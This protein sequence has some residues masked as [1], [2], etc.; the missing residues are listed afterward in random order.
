M[1]SFKEFEEQKRKEIE[2]GRLLLMELIDKK[3]KSGQKLKS[4]EEEYF[5]SLLNLIRDMNGKKVHDDTLDLEECKNYNFIEAYGLLWHDLNGIKKHK[6][7]RGEYYSKQQ[8]ERFV[9]YLNSEFINWEKI[10]Q[11]ENHKDSR[12]NN[13][14]IETRRHLKS[15]KRQ[16]DFFIDGIFY[17]NRYYKSVRKKIILFSKYV[18]LKAVHLFDTI[19]ENEV[20]FSIKEER[21]TFNF[22]SLVHIIFGHYPGTTN[23][24]IKDKSFF[25][26]EFHPD[27]IVN[28]LDKIFELLSNS[29]HF[30]MIE[31]NC[32]YIKYDNVN[33]AIWFK[34]VFTQK[35]GVKG[36]LR[37][38]RLDSFYPITKQYEL[39]RLDNKYNSVAISPILEYYKI[40]PI[41][42]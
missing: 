1:N 22:Y 37:M 32:I 35:K 42:T 28:E 4:Y 24:Y 14:G 11:Q 10:V 6:N 31:N 17:A 19:G 25:S 30:V 8:I 36:N 41:E 27:K 20:E 29:E 38:K 9:N 13:I 2:N 40:H 3:I 18:Y 21:I 5:C 16:P 33:Y 23:G 26:P 12:L 15:L 39:S 34:D 7:H